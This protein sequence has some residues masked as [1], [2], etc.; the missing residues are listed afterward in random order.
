MCLCTG[1]CSSLQ[2]GELGQELLRETGRDD[3]LESARGGGRG[4]QLGEL[5]ADPLGG[6][7][8]EAVVHLLDRPH[9]ARGG[10]EFELRGEPRRAEHPQRVVGERDL[11]VERR[12]EPLGREVLH[13]AERIDELALGQ[14]DR[15][16]VDGEVAPGQVGLQVLAERHRRLAV[17]LRV[18]LLAEGRDLEDLVALAGADRPELHAD[19]VQPLGPAAQDLRRLLRDGVGREV[20]IAPERPRPAAGPAP[21]HPR[22]RARDRPGGNARRAR[23]RSGGSRGARRRSDATGRP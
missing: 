1:S 19:Q 18:D 14:P 4:E 10:G 11:G 3:Q 16:R 22:G 13:A 12:V 6:H 21:R 2:R 15:H 8:L 5:V 17:L 20:E 9:H 23:W 7:D